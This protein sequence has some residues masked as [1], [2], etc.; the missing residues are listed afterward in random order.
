[1]VNFAD[2]N[3][4]AVDAA[5]PSWQ[6]VLAPGEFLGGPSAHGNS[7]WSSFQQCPR[8]FYLAHVK[9]LRG[10]NLSPALEIGGL[11]HEAVARY[12]TGGPAAAWELV[13]RA[14]EVTPVVG[15]EVRRIL[16]AWLLF[17]GPDGVKPKPPARVVELA[18]EITEPFPYSCRIDAVCRQDDGAAIYEMKTAS[19]MDSNLL[20]GYE[21]NPQF[22]GQASMWKHC[23]QDKVWGP[24]KE[25][26]VDLVVKT[27]QVQLEEVHVKIPDDCVRAWEKNMRHLW[28][29]MQHCQ[30]Y[31]IWP[32][33]PSN[34][35]MYAARCTYYRYCASLGK[36]TEGLVKKERGEW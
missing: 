26:V 16:S 13:D 8:K 4:D 29:E 12:Y 31:A 7:W 23:K 22:L 9:R 19:R 3:F 6:T 14:S 2:F 27:K 17:Y 1:M 18:L 35:V 15:A 10:T 11:M 5:A 21:M 36:D 20:H 28:G 33:R 25:F 32:Q 24:L 30:T 34:C